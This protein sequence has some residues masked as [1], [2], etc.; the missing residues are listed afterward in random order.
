MKKANL[1]ILITVLSFSACSKN[2]NPTVEPVVPQCKIVSIKEGDDPA[3]TYTYDG[4]GKV[5]LVTNLYGFGTGT[6]TYQAGKI[7]FTD[8]NGSVNQSLTTDASGRLLSDG[9]DT[10]KY[11]SD[12]YLIEKY[13]NFVSTSVPEYVLSY[14]NGNLTKVTTDNNETIDITYD[15]TES[16]QDLIGYESPLW[17]PLLFNQHTFSNITATMIGKSSKN[18]VKTIVLKRP[19]NGKI[20]QFNETYTYK[21]DQEGKITSLTIVSVSPGNFFNGTSII[22]FSYQCK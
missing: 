10:Y 6:F 7:N 22:N 19:E 21:K 2:D 5:S 17:S 13:W 20:L 15:E 18:L 16:Y 1:L 14:S 3:T 4:N 8:I 9:T 11:N 12:G